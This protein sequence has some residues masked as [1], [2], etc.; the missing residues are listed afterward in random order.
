MYFN[1]TRRLLQFVFGIQLGLSSAHADYFMAKVDLASVEALVSK[2]EQVAKTYES[3]LGLHDLAKLDKSTVLDWST[4]ISPF[5]ADLH[6][7]LKEFNSSDSTDTTLRPYL[8]TAITKVKFQIHDVAFMTKFLA[9]QLKSDYELIDPSKKLSPEETRALKHFSTS[10]PHVSLFKIMNND[11]KDIS[12]IKTAYKIETAD[13]QRENVKQTSIDFINKQILTLKKNI[14]VPDALPSTVENIKQMLLS[15]EDEPKGQV[16]AVFANRLYEKFKTYFMS[17]TDE[18]SLPKD[19]IRRENL[20]NDDESLMELYIKIVFLKMKPETIKLET[21]SGSATHQLITISTP[22]AKN[23]KDIE[24]SNAKN[25][26][27]KNNFILFN[28]LADLMGFTDKSTFMGH[29][30]TTSKLTD[31]SHWLTIKSQL[32]S[33]LLNTYITFSGVESKL[34]KATTTASPSSSVPTAADGDEGNDSA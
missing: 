22:L 1:T 9:L 8:E 3:S 24:V 29:T 26:D 33:L 14:G 27:P 21:P 13:E 19:I 34:P 11:V 18:K 20:I 32:E 17:P 31:I 2:R 16:A 23:L 10:H 25:G 5:R 30:Y 7:T 12:G 15:H 6:V 4:S 28:E